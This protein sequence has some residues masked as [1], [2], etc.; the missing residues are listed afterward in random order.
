VNVLVFDIETVPDVETGRRL[1]E[2]TDLTDKEVAQVMHSK[3]MQETEGKSEFLRHPAQRVV[4]IS[5]VL[6]TPTRVHIW[7]IGEPGSPEAEL[8]QRFFDGIE[9]YSPML[10]S[11][12]G[13]GFDLPVLH[14]R[15]LLHG[16]NAGRYWETGGNDPGFR[17]NNYLNRFH[18][19]HTD[20]MDVIAG[21][22]PRAFASLHDVAS[23]LGFPGK[24]GMS[25]ADVWERF[26]GGD[27]EAIRNYCETDVLN[28]YLIYLRYELMRGKQTPEGYEAGC[29]ALRQALEQ[30][31]RP[32]LQA[33]LKAW[34]GVSPQV[35]P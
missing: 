18:E 14:Y 19:R 27:I 8:I 33:F 32:H 9:R 25:G 20:L 13:R 10:V 17:W 31:S 22:E 12:N 24:L 28:T 26:L 15:G 29:R 16:V 21:Y 1:Y 7:S 35:H 6:R 5:L 4:A 3:R 30:E 34:N 2:L 23:L 11:W